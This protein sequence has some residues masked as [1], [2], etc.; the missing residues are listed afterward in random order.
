MLPVSGVE[1]FTLKA[2]LINSVRIELL[3]KS[4][5]KD[6]GD[7]MLSMLSLETPPCNRNCRIMSISCSLPFAMERWNTL[8]PEMEENISRSLHN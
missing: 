4:I 7:K 3:L 8:I 1:I 6:S 2:L 5:A